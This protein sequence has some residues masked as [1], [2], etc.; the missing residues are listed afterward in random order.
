MVISS[1]MS[2]AAAAIV[3]PCAAPL[4]P[5]VIFVVPLFCPVAIV[6]SVTCPKDLTS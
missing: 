6:M 1:A 4:A 3:S 2:L 5:L